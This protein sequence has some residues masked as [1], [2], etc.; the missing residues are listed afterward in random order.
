MRRACLAG[1]LALL[2]ALGACSGLDPSASLSAAAVR[3]TPIPVTAAAVGPLD[4]RTPFERKALRA[5]LP[6]FEFKPIQ[7]YSQGAVKEALGAFENGMQVLQI[8]PDGSSTRIGQVHGV[9]ETVT[10][11]S[12]ERVGRSFAE[13]GGDRLSC[14]PGL[15]GYGGLVLCRSAAANVLLIYS[16][17]GHRAPDGQMPPPE[18][19]RKAVLQQI[20]WRPQA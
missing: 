12:G 2:L 4:P 18:A 19:L 3:G 20:V 1:P 7:A 15:D 11:P 14:R 5:A 8:F 17:P 10:G 6:G 13:T 16:V 9:R